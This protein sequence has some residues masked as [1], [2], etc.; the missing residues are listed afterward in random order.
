ML[1]NEVS[2]VTESTITSAT[3][4]KLSPPVVV[5]GANFF[6]Y[7]V[8]EWIQWATLLYV[9]ILILLK[10]PECVLFVRRIY[11][12]RQWLSKND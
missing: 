5:S 8:T 1:N 11:S 6:G 12:F 3:V 4:A 10:I 9:V 2:S 7:S